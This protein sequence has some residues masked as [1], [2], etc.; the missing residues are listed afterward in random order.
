MTMR[1]KPATTASRRGGYDYMQLFSEWLLDDTDNRFMKDAACKGLPYEMF[2]PERGAN[3]S[4]KE[5]KAICAK[6]PVKQDCLRYATNNRIDFGIWGGTSAN[7]RI[8]RARRALK[9]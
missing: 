1:K 7:Q 6:C 9:P 5:A 4:L 8:R 2:F 3:T